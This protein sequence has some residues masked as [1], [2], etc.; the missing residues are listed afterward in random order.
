MRSLLIPSL[1]LL[2]VACQ[3]PPF[4]QAYPGPLLAA[5]EH[6]RIVVVPGSIPRFRPSIS[7][8][9]GKSTDPTG[10]TTHYPPE[11]F[12]LPGRHYFTVLFAQP[13]F[14]TEAALWIDAEAGRTYHVNWDLQAHGMRFWVVDGETRAVVGGIV[15]SEPH[16]GPED[17]VCV[18]RRSM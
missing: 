5:E 1:L 18:P 13:H 14:W 15:G 12:V 6:A 17:Q 7:C 9:D 4:F 2:C 10:I 11:A 3:P 16:P 8:V